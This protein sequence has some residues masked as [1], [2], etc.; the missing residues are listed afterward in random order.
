ML[1]IGYDSKKDLKAAIGSRLKYRETS[2]FG[3]EYKSTG[4][5]VVAHRP[6]L[7]TR[8]GREFFATVTMKND[9]ITNVN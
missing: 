9:L 2:M 6:S 4:S 3:E 7:T 5:F 8:R 1:V